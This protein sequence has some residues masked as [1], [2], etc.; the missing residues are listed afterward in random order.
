LFAL[1]VVRIVL[2]HNHLHDTGVIPQ[3]NKKQ[4]TMVANYVH[5]T[6]ESYGFPDRLAA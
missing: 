4:L 2:I 3:V 1:G 6:V 5:P